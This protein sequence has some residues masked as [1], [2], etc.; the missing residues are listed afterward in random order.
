MG[1]MKII[2]TVTATPQESM[3]FFILKKVR[4]IWDNEIIQC[5]ALYITLHTYINS[6]LCILTQISNRLH[7]N[8]EHI[9]ETCQNNIKVEQGHFITIDN[10]LCKKYFVHVSYNTYF[11]R[12]YYTYSTQHYNEMRS[13]LTMRNEIYIL[14]YCFFRLFIIQI[15]NMPKL[16]E[17]KFEQMHV[18]FKEA[19]YI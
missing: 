8:V 1:Y 6:G 12:A 7:K 9:D 3:G 15:S 14:L 17:N 13:Q 11:I 4:T 16:N 19:E 10:I 5:I 2:P 18:Q